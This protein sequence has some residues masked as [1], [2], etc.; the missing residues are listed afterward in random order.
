MTAR[1]T[2]FIIPAILLLIAAAPAHAQLA[3]GSVAL[4][5]GT[6][7]SSASSG[8]SSGPAAP[9]T[10]NAF[11]GSVPGKL[12]PGVAQISL[13]NAI[14]RG[15]KANLGLLLSGQDVVNARGERWKKLSA[16]LPNA[17]TTSYVDGSQIDLAEFGF[18]FKFPPSLGVSFPS[19]VGPFG[20][21]DARAYVTQSLFDL[22]AIN[23]THAASQSVKAAE[24]TAK[25][26]RDLVVLAVGYNYL[27][28]IAD[29]S[30]IETVA[31]QVNTAQALYNQASDQV[32]AGTS[33]AIDGLRAQVELKTRQQ[34]LIQA[35]NDFAIQKLTLARVIGLAPGQEYDLTDKSPY[36][37]FTGL[38]LEEALQRAYASRSDYQAASA[39][40]RAA[41]YTRK[42]ARAEYYPSLSFSGDYGLAGTYETLA[43]HGV[44]DVRGTLSIPI[45]QGG[46][47]HGDELVADAQVEQNRQKL[48]NIRAQIDADVRT[49]FL[50][51]QS[52][53]QQV[54]VAKSNIDL[55]QQTLDQSRDR[56]AAG[57][58]DTVEVVQSQEQV[59]SA[60]DS[61]INSLYNFNYAKISLARA[62]GLGEASVREYFKGK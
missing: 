19:I 10:Q 45:F 28:A 42:S 60:N 51:L 5:N 15:L 50:N 11:Q 47:V 56:F 7:S 9:A 21:Y 40:L 31:A 53:A 32:Q 4:Q 41:E 13:Q 3:A 55:A 26:A 62:M 18:S 46:K 49:A 30:R 29:E 25:D 33:P 14:D 22:K 1:S 24:Y 6:S 54:E 61:Y 20:Y 2:T 16:L 52:S 39:T 17:T 34:Q 36:E 23:D 44:F 58:T 48:E 38:T 27:Q 57:V 37:P 35:K 12:E 43:T 59:A 8:G